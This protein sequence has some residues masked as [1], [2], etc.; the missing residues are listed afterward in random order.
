MRRVVPLVAAIVALA[1]VLVTAMLTP[2]EPVAGSHIPVPVSRLLACP[3]G[4]PALGT[5]T[6]S[7]TDQQD[8]TAGPLGAVPEAPS[9]AAQFENPAS[10]V[11][12]RG[13][14]TVGGV[15]LYSENGQN[16]AVPCTAPLTSG[17]WNGVTTQDEAVTLILTN[18]DIGPAAVDVLLFDQ[19]GPLPAPGLRD[20][21]VAPGAT[22]RV[23]IHEVAPSVTPISVQFRATRGRVLAG[24]RTIG[25]TGFEWQLP[26]ASP[27]TDLVIAAIPPGEGTRTLSV[28]NPDQTARAVIDLQIIGEGGSFPPL[29]LDTVEVAPARTATFDLT[30]ALGTEAAAVRLTADHPVTATIQ[31]RDTDLAAV[32]A[33]PALNGA[34]VLPPV[35]GTLWVANPAEE[36][37][38]LTLTSD[39]PNVSMQMQRIPLPGRKL[40]AVPFPATG[41]TVRVASDSEAVR[42]SLVLTEPTISILPIWSGGP[43]ATA[44]VP[45]F[46]PGLG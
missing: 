23:L 11:V 35:G 19:T 36:S 5:T 9:A 12:V 41:T 40:T 13:S 37:A 42:T 45:G 7:V 6:V 38:I 46:N 32:S 18:V 33:Q 31:L 17:V 20:I 29:G 22:E 1:A 4:D 44:Q 27:G 34:V 14:S 3:V 28:T 2:V 16:M 15:S 30:Q 43:V 24:L 26:Q 21:K 25:A 10:P 8:F 39:D